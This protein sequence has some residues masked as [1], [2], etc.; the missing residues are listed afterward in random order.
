VNL[1]PALQICSPRFSSG[2]RRREGAFSLI[3][4]MVVVALLSVIILGLMAMFT[5]TQRAFRLGMSQTDVLESGRVATDLLV[6]EL[7]QVTPAYRSNIVNFYADVVASGTQPLPPVSGNFSR[8]NVMQDLFFVTRQNQTWSGIG[9]FVRTNLTAPNQYGAVG[10]LYRFETNDS[11]FQFANNPGGLVSGFNRA[12][13]GNNS[14]G[15]SKILDG[16][17]GFKIRAFETNGFWINEYNSVN[18]QAT[19]YPVNES[20]CWF[21][22]NAVP[23][24]VELEIGVLEQQTFERY[25]AI[26]VYSVATNYLANHVGNVHVFR[27]RI[28]VRNVDMAAYQ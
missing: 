10:T 9:Y 12:R 24:F 28:H 1:K 15:V 16:V 8:T 7:E 22:S 14:Q 18:I 4:I 23:A 17:V 21:Q 25:K 13:N 19:R 5:Q 11:A 26:P 6:R 3:E 2:T 27:Q 20:Y